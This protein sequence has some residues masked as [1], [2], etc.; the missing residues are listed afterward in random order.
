MRRSGLCSFAFILALFWIGAVFA[1]NSEPITV[2][3][4]INA[5]GIEFSPGVIP[6]NTP[7]IIHVINKAGVPVELENSDTSV[8]VYANMDKTYKVGLPAGNYVFFNDFNTHTKAATL[9]VK[10]TAA[11]LESTSIPLTTQTPLTQ[12]SLNTS[13]ILFIVWRESVEA[14]LVVGVVYSWLTQLKTG[15]RSGFFCLWAGVITGLLCAVLLSFLLM[16]VNHALSPDS[17]NFFQ[18]GIT[19]LAASMI[20]Y[21]VKWMRGNSRSLK[22]NMHHSLEKNT[23]THWRNISIFTV[24]SVAITREASE[25]CIFIYGLGFSSDFSIKTMSFLGLGVLLAIGTILLLQLGNKIFSWRFFFRITEVLL[26]LLGGGLLLSCIDRLVLSGFLTPLHSK[27]WNTSFLISEGGFFAP[28]LSSFTGYR[29]APSLMDIII[30][31]A[32]WLVI[33]FLLKTKKNKIHAV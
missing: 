21:M 13:E 6:E 23:S 26:L 11:I 33:Y 17:A 28:M 12:S 8:E 19:F 10:K 4:F 24:V 29:A 32:Y 20:V 14:L 9:V 3:A 1:K 5:T 16:T 2:N 31:G 30:Y 15:R 7:F 25:A 27:I 18:I 22:K